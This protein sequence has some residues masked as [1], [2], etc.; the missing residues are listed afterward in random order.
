MQKLVYLCLFFSSI[1]Y[2]QE[3]NIKGKT[4]EIKNGIKTPLPFAVMHI[5]GTGKGALANVDG[6]LKFQLK[7]GLYKILI[8]AMGYDTLNSQ[9]QVSENMVL[10]FVF[11]LKPKTSTMNE[12]VVKLQS[13]KATTASLQMEIKEGISV[14]NKLSSKQ[15]SEQG[16]S[17][18]Q[19][20]VGKIVGVSTDFG[21]SSIYIRGLEDRYNVS[22]LNGL[23][24]P[25]PN[26]ELRLVALDLF[27]TSIVSV[28]EVTKVM[29]NGLYGD[30]AGGAVNI[31]TKQ[32]F[33]HPTLNF[34]LGLGGNSQTTFQ[35][36]LTSK[37][38]KW[39]YFGWDDG[40][41][42]L[43]NKV[44]KNAKIATSAIYPNGLYHSKKGA[45]TAFKNN[46]NPQR[47]KA[48]PNTNFK[49]EGGTFFSFA[50]N[51]ESKTE[52]GIGF[53]VSANHKTSYNTKIGKVHLVNAQNKSLYNYAMKSYTQNTASAGLFNLHYQINADNSLSFNYLLLNTSSDE[54]KETKGT[55]WDYI[56]SLFARRLTYKQNTLH[57]LQL[58]GKNNL[59]NHRL[60]LDWGLSYSK[61]NSQVPDR[62]QLV[63]QYNKN[64]KKHTKNYTWFSQD[65][66]QN[67]RFFS[68]LYENEI[69]GNINA[70][71]NLKYFEQM[72]KTPQH[73]LLIN[74]GYKRKSRHFK[75]RQFN[76]NLKVLDAQVGENADAYQPDNY[77][78]NANL[79]QGLFYIEE[80]ANP[81]NHYE[82]KQNV[83]G[84][85][86]G[87][88]LK[89]N[90]Q[91]TLV[92]TL[93]AESVYQEVKNRNQQQAKKI[94]I[95]RI[96]G[97]SLIPSIAL[98]YEINDKNLLRF[99]SSRTLTRPK[100]SELAPFQ[101]VS[102]VA[103]V[104]QEGNPK[105]QNGI[106][107]NI[108]VRYEFYGK[109][110]NM[111]T[112][113]VFY[114]HL[115]NPI[116]RVNIAAAS[117]QLLTFKNLEAANLIGIEFEFSQNL[118]F[119]S[120][121]KDRNPWKSFFLHGNL[122]YIYSQI[123]IHD[124]TG[125]VTNQKRP[126][127][128]ASPLMGNIALKWLKYGKKNK[129]FSA[130]LSYQFTGRRMA[131][132]GAQG[133]GDQYDKATH[134]LNLVIKANL[135]KQISIGLSCKNI[136]NTKITSLQENTQ[137][138]QRD[139][140]TLSY[141]RSGVDFAFSFTYTPK[142]K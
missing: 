100:F 40:T 131:A 106:N 142:F 43:P 128:G 79:N 35:S 102:N 75:Y 32:F 73:Q 38:G 126:L 61:T 42:Q 30:F 34:S 123:N 62:R 2:T 85:S 81:A 82:A 27:P 48:L 132:S 122:S 65:V 53:A 47:K 51:N 74:V 90:K 89:L 41:R 87:I 76:Y 107:Y 59:L 58:L 112:L 9:I 134:F 141:Y 133:I 70:I 8:T 113:G 63:F 17:N 86:L 29:T 60:Q 105:L 13:N 121:K 18:M 10:P 91:T 120:K 97:W 71:W 77:L 19:E 130:T 116:E 69:S 99:I 54:T 68:N 110:L 14:V 55:H 104:I 140:V 16:G 119:L 67:H 135:S 95:N 15:L 26:T 7:K 45:G 92:P 50:K 114:K 28:L 11:V 49:I 52:R 44:I 64:S 111:I 118:S 136:L 72:H 39:D 101:Y 127:Q 96:M 21:S 37:G 36:F 57:V 78:S 93:R 108:D 137:T 31:R 129:R 103:G 80:F 3:L 83:L 23:P 84:T 20:G 139:F 98:K 4:V 109:M 5:V 33:V 24:L 12:I 117:G 125:F 25:S 66:N 6:E 88:N 138:P 124:T 115:K 94:E 1:T 46:F 22:Y 56:D